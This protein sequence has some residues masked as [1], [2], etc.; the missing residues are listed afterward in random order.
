MFSSVSP[1]VLW[2]GLIS[3]TLAC[4]GDDGR[5][6]PPTTAT[7]VAQAC[8]QS[9]YVPGQPRTASWVSVTKP[10]TEPDEN[11]PE[12]RYYL[13]DHWLTVPLVPE[14]YPFTVREVQYE[15]GS[16]ADP[17][18]AAVTPHQ[19]Q[20]FVGSSRVP[21]DS[22]TVVQTWMTEVEA[23][24]LRALVR[25]VVEPEITLEQGQVLFLAIQQPQGAGGFPCPVACRVGDDVDQ[26]GYR[27][28]SA[29]APYGW[30]DMS[31][32]PSY[33]SDPTVPWASMSDEPNARTVPDIAFDAPSD[34]TQDNCIA[35]IEYVDD[36]RVKCTVNHLCGDD[37]YRMACLSPTSCACALN[38]EPNCPGGGEPPCPI[39][40]PDDLC[41]L[42]P[43][44]AEAVAIE[45]CGW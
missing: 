4:S 26:V 18:C 3:V 27:S 34:G 9:D 20:V 11:D 21:P 32:Y 37:G 29:E 7:E 42:S 39:E 43:R 16:A 12:Q 10:E 33:R 40:K 15:L 24:T 1:G 38:S 31:S 25:H 14:S 19:A 44:E 6:S 23:G 5:G 2:L 36:A 22:P 13:L 8:Q 17:P 45:L 35:H 41:K 30:Q 28:T